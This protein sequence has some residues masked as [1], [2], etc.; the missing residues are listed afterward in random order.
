MSTAR[1]SAY[2]RPAVPWATAGAYTPAAVANG[3]SASEAWRCTMS[4]ALGPSVTLGG[5]VSQRTVTRSSATHIMRYIISSLFVMLLA[6]P[7]WGQCEPEGIY[8]VDEPNRTP[9]ANLKDRVISGHILCLGTEY[10][11]VAFRSA[12]PGIWEVD[13]SQLPASQ[14]YDLAEACTD[15]V[16][17][18][19]AAQF[20]LEKRQLYDLTMTSLHWDRPSGKR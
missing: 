10:C 14:R 19:C 13:V 16:T 3:C 18:G 4:R 8:S 12:Y 2:V 11:Q 17:W 5:S 9:P 15:P 7:T 20:T 6:S 1:K